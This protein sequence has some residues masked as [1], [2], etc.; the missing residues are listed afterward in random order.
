MSLPQPVVSCYDDNS[1]LLTWYGKNRRVIINIYKQK[2]KGWWGK[3]YDLLTNF[4]HRKY[5]WF[6]IQKTSAGGE[7]A[8]GTLNEL[9]PDMLKLWLDEI[10]N[11]IQKGIDK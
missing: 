6:M 2:Y 4:R 10:D 11:D 7:I 8:N 9:D 1:I 3:L 5:D